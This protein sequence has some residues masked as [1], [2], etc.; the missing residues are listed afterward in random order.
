MALACLC[1]I[2]LCCGLSLQSYCF[3]DRESVTA[4]ID[5]FRVGFGETI[6]PMA[7][8]ALATFVEQHATDWRKQKETKGP[9]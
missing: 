2:A 9:E 7:L 6:M 3:I 1:F 4:D 5:Y 8:A